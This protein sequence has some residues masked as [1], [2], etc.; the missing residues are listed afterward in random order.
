MHKVDGQPAGTLKVTIFIE[1][2]DNDHGRNPGHY[3]IR[4][5]TVY[6]EHYISEA[7]ARTC[8]ADWYSVNKGIVAASHRVDATWT[9][10]P[11]DFPIPGSEF[12]P[13]K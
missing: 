5:V 2:P 9:P 12:G 10:Y 1:A 11:V 3:R 7:H 6:T 13:R 4:R 8:V